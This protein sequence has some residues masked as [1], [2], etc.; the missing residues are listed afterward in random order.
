MKKIFI[1]TLFMFFI[2][3]IPAVA[4]DSEMSPYAD[5]T[6]KSSYRK[7]ETG[8]KL[9]FYSTGNYTSSGV[10]VGGMSTTQTG[11]NAFNYFD[12]IVMTKQSGKINPY[13]KCTFRYVAAGSYAPASASVNKAL[14]HNY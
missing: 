11:H 9:T 6:H 5:M 4:L 13:A 14:I 2:F 7:S 10:T 8:V 1:S 3:V 12:K